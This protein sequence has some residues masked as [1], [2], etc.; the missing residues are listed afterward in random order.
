[1]EFFLVIYI[2]TFIVFLFVWRVLTISCNCLV[3]TK[4]GKFLIL[5]KVYLIHVIKVAKVNLWVH[6]GF[7]SPQEHPKNII[8]II[9]MYCIKNGS[10]CD[11][12]HVLSKITTKFRAMVLGFNVRALIIIMVI[13]QSRWYYDFH[14]GIWKYRTISSLQLCDSP[15]SSLQDHVT[16]PIP[17]GSKYVPPMVASLSMY[18]SCNSPTNIIL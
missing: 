15:S 9:D 16:V 5:R 13:R 3:E 6:L 12:T 8:T 11:G 18:T 7:H 1:M 14:R 2:K 10:I 17:V 4:T